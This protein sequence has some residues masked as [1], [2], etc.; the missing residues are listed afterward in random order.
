MPLTASR[1]MNENCAE[2]DRPG[3]WSG[4]RELSRILSTLWLGLRFRATHFDGSSVKHTKDE[5][6]V[7]REQADSDKKCGMNDHDDGTSN[8]KRRYVHVTHPA[9]LPCT[10]IAAKATIIFT[11]RV[12]EARQTRK[13]TESTPNPESRPC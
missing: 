12:T 4:C 8:M 6:S 9:E 13:G 11:H 1:E 5:Q 7:Y 2:C 10:V 3:A